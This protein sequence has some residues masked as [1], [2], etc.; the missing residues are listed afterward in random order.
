MH[1]EDLLFNN[2]IKFNDNKKIINNDGFYCLNICDFEKGSSEYLEAYGLPNG[3]SLCFARCLNG[4]VYET[5]TGKIIKFVDDVEM[6]YDIGEQFYYFE[7]P[8]YVSY[9]EISKEEYY[10]TVNSLKTNDNNVLKV[11]LDVLNDQF[12]HATSGYKEL[13]EM[14]DKHKAKKKIK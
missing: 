6:I 4:V 3:R 12:R 5:F 7:E 1:Y 9:K 14:L 13:K 10:N 2:E 11:Y 8:C